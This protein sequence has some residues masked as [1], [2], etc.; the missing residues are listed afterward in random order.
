MGG[1]LLAA[2]R[3]RS[4][5]IGRT[6]ALEALRRGATLCI[7]AVDAGRLAGDQEL[8]RHVAE[9][10]AIAWLT[11]DEL[12]QLLGVESVAI[13]SVTHDAI[14]AELKKLR[15]AMAA[16]APLTGEDAECRRPEAR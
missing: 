2:R 16:G 9:G 8:S 11:K 15:V 10:R 12:A 1:L 4:I 7:V 13:C 14:A 6:A 3:T 5:A